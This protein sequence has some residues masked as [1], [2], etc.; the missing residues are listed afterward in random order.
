MEHPLDITDVDL[1]S[2][3]IEKPILY[4]RNRDV[5]GKK[6]LIFSVSQHQ[7]GKNVDEMKKIFLYY[8]ERLER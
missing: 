1:D 8:I 2:T 3:F 6:L 7:K 5:D 4:T